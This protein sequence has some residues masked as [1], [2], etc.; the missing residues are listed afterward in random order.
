MGISLSAAIGLQEGLCYLTVVNRC[1]SYLYSS[2][3]F[4]P[5]ADTVDIAGLCLHLIEPINR[6]GLRPDNSQVFWR[7]TVGSR[8]P[9]STSLFR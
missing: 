4:C 5:G 8:P 7:R 1:F 6:E 9:F 2:I 3:Q